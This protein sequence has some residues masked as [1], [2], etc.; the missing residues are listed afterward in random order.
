MSYQ[1]FPSIY[2]IN[3]KSKINWNWITCL[4]GSLV[5]GIILIIIAFFSMEE[6]KK[7]DE[8]GNSTVQTKFSDNGKTY[9]IFGIIMAFLPPFI[10]IIILFW[11]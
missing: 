3:E 1:S 5:V 4:S 2:K 8:N 10:F 6:I 11:D 9:L 7:T